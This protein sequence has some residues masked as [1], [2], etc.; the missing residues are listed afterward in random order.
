MAKIIDFKTREVLADLP[1]KLTSR[2]T[3]VWVSPKKCNLYAIAVTSLGATV[4]LDLIGK[5]SNKITKKV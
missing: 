4:Y 5:S 3:A 1:V 2:I